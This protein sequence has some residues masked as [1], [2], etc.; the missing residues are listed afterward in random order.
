MSTEWGG[1]EGE[2]NSKE[3]LQFLTEPHVNRT[4]RR[5]KFLETPPILRLCM[6][7]VQPKP[8]EIFETVFSLFPHVIYS[9]HFLLSQPFMLTIFS[10][11]SRILTIWWMEN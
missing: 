8:H 5:L 2:L 4:A 7:K 3:T 11:P 6:P 10:R 9:P 1:V